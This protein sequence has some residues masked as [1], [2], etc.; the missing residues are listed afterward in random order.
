MAGVWKIV[1]PPQKKHP[2]NRYFFE[3]QRTA[4]FKEPC[5][6][7]TILEKR[8][9]LNNLNFYD[10]ELFVYN[11]KMYYF[12]TLNTWVIYFCTLI[13][14]IN[15][16]LLNMLFHNDIHVSKCTFLCVFHCEIYYH[17]RRKVLYSSFTSIRERNPISNGQF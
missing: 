1:T 13:I 9:C 11:I 8:Q 4:I 14:K 16:Y 17:I 6:R 3:L 15:T 10:I 5:E 7:N 2:K 12:Y